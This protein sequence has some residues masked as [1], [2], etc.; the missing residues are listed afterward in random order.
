MA[1]KYN[2]KYNGANVTYKEVNEAQRAGNVPIEL[3]E[4]QGMVQD[5]FMHVSKPLKTKYSIKDYHINIIEGYY[6]LWNDECGPN[7]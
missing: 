5:N 6:L 4:Y 3:D 7:C 1:Q 2:V